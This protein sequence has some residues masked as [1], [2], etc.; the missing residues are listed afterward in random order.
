MIQAYEQ[1]RQDLSKAEASTLL[2]L[3]RA[4]C[5]KPEELI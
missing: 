3:S 1:R 2:N 4:L 5:C